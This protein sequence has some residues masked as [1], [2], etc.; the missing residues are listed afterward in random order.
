M[1]NKSTTFQKYDRNRYRKIYPITRFPASTAFR[2]TREVILES[3]LVTFDITDK[4]SGDLKGFYQTLPTIT[5]GV[6]VAETTSP[7]A[8]QGNVNVFLS[9][10]SINTTTGVVSFTLESSA[11][12]TGT[13]ALQVMDIK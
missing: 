3:L 7:G 1:A 13:V 5:V 8:P 11:E 12:F 10:L 6:S 4:V 2:T 9:S